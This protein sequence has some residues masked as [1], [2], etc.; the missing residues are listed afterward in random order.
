MKN[1]KINKNKAYRLAKELGIKV[2]F[3]FQNNRRK[4][5]T[6]S[7]FKPSNNDVKIEVLEKCI[8]EIFIH[9]DALTKMQLYVE[10][11]DDEIGWLGIAL[12]EKNAIHITDVLL[13]EQEVNSTTT[14]ITPEGLAEFGE[15]LLKQ[16]NGMEIWNNIK[17]WGH[18]HVNMSTSPS[19]Q[20]NSQME[21]FSKNGHDWFIRI[22][23]NK[24]G[25]LRVDLYEYNL[26]I[27]YNNLPW[28]ACMSKEEIEI[29]KQIN[30]LYEQ[31]EEFQEKRINKYKGS[32]K[33]EMLLKIKKKSY[34]QWNGYGG[35]YNQYQNIQDEKKNQFSTKENSNRE[36]ITSGE[37]VLKWFSQE[38]LI[39]IGEC[40]NIYDAK[41]VLLLY[42]YGYHEFTYDEIL[43]ILDKAKEVAKNY[44]FFD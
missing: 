28:S 9:P 33:S 6:I 43:I 18:S 34:Q 27:I 20:D 22:I 2:S 16:K 39:D 38:E 23:A 40:E 35:Y 31:L 5:M 21:T 3:N 4:T 26:G 30:K 13:F 25:D 37:D 1:F 36:H 29:E 10:E 42:G 11:C 19:G 12:K 8:P 14:E 17:V 7:C 24:K 44:Y 32:I 41:E 15:T